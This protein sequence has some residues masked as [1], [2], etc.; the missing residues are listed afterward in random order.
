MINSSDTTENFYLKN[1][2]SSQNSHYYPG[3]FIVDASQVF[4]QYNLGISEFMEA[5]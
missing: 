5:Q 1:F 3:I 2:S 4:L